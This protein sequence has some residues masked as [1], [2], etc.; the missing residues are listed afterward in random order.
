MKKHLLF[1]LISL[2]SNLY[3]T[4]NND[5][6]IFAQEPTPFYLVLNGVKQND[7]AETNV[8]IADLNASANSVRIIF[9]DN[10][11]PDLTKSIYFD[12]TNT[13]YSFRIVATKKKGYKLR[14]F[15][16][17]PKAYVSSNNNVPTIIY[18]TVESSP[19]PSTSNVVVQETVTTTT[20]TGAQDNV[21]VNA[22]LDGVGIN[23]SVNV[24]DNSMQS[25]QVQIESSGSLNLNMNVNVNENTDFEDNTNL[26]MN[27]NVN[28]NLDNVQSSSYSSTTTTT[29]TTTSWG[30]STYSSNSQNEVSSG[31]DNSGFNG[32]CE[33]GNINGVLNAIDNESFNDDKMM[34]AKQATKN[35]CL[36]VG[37]I[38]QIMEKF[39][40]EDGK[41]EFAKLAYANCLNKDEYY[42][43]N[44]AFTFSS[45]K[46]ELNEFIGNQ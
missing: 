11:I 12:T 14:G 23:M 36:N 30:G 9:K 4:Q 25:D 15:D 20:T 26:S 34:V 33:I 16:R 22:N 42:L 10:T 18:K 29:T 41:L 27:M 35:K 13:Q 43:V 1:I 39:S 37:Q 24:N 5:L 28:D 17:T 2:L 46:S 6:V 3:F 45:S 21:N 32:D 31:T 44:Q 38:K 8:K 40:F 19:L 7:K